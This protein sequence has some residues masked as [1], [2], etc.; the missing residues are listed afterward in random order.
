MKISLLKL[1]LRFEAENCVKFTEMFSDDP[2][3]KFPRPMQPYV[4]S[5][6]L[7]MSF[8]VSFS[9]GDQEEGRVVGIERGK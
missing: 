4:W 9:E 6:L 2:N 8:E 1:D 5:D 7:V 3:V